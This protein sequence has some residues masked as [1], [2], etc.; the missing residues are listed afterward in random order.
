MSCPADTS[1]V[2][3]RCLRSPLSV[4]SVFLFWRQPVASSWP[5]SKEAPLIIRLQGMHGVAVRQLAN[6]GSQTGS[7]LL[8]HAGTGLLIFRPL[9]RAESRNC[10][11]FK[12][13]PP[14]FWSYSS[15]D[16]SSAPHAQ[17]T[18][19]GGLLATPS[20][21]VVSPLHSMHGVAVNGQFQEQSVVSTMYGLLPDTSVLD[22]SAASHR[23][24]AR[25]YVTSSSCPD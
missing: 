22:D 16:P 10:E 14:P 21:A 8:W 5:R 24:I 11:T 25:D 12:T 13:S 2:Y 6:S 3:S 19:V 4:G 7:S 23:H 18:V 20:V 15:S 1:N 17:M 9:F